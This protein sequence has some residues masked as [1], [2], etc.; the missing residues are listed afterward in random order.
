VSLEALWGAVLAENPRHRA[1]LEGA[2]AGLR[3]DEVTELDAYVA[4]LAAEGHPIEYLAECY[5]TVVLDTLREQ[6]WFNR[7]GHYR[8]STFAEVA[9]DVYHN[10]DYM[11]RYMV[12][13]ALTAFVWPNHAAMR[14]HFLATLPTARGGAYLEI[15]PGHG[16]YFLSAIRRARFERYVGVDISATSVDLTRRVVGHFLGGLPA[17]VDIRQ[18]DFL[19]DAVPEAPFAAIVMGEV[20]EH[21]EA[22]GRFL[23]RIADLSDADTHIHVTTCIN[24]PAVDHIYLFRTPEQI[25]ALV[26]DAGLAVQDRC[27]MPYVG[28]TLEECARDRLAVNVAYTLRKSR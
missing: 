24:A 12:G 2:L 9:G 19:A 1:F 25:E 18:G 17:H 15:G 13:L 7:H 4:W 16:F 6:I 8:H 28:K 26:R 21:V 5:N 22:P 27:L 14:R 3:P 20:L 23:A 11:R 10:P